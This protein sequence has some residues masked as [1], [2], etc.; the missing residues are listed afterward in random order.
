VKAIG[1]IIGELHRC[2]PVVIREN[3][4]FSPGSRVARHSKKLLDVFG[5]ITPGSGQ[6]FVLADTTAPGLLFGWL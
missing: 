2:H 3:L 6:R 5:R 4:S 1:L